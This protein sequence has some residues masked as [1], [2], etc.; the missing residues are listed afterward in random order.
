MV[1]VIDPRDPSVPGELDGLNSHDIPLERMVPVAHDVGAARR[2]RKRGERLAGQQQA[3]RLP[4]YENPQLAMPLFPLDDPQCPVDTDPS[5]PPALLKI[6][7]ALPNGA[8]LPYLGEDGRPLYP[9]PLVVTDDDLRDLCG[10]GR[11][12]VELH[13]EFD[14]RNPESRSRPLAQRY[15]EY[16]DEEPR[17]WVDERETLEGRPQGYG[18]PGAPPP[19]WQG[20]P[21][22]PGWNPSWGQPPPTVVWYAQRHGSWPANW[23]PPPA[24]WIPDGYAPPGTGIAPWQAPPAKPTG[25]VAELRGVL[26][27]DP[28]LKK[29]VMGAL[30]AWL[31]KTLSGSAD[32]ED[33]SIAKMK[34]EADLA[35]ENARIEQD[36]QDRIDEKE[37]QRKHEERLMQLQLEQ[38]RVTAA[39]QATAAA[40][41]K[42]LLQQIQEV[43]QTASALGLGGSDKGSSSVLSELANLADTPMGEKIGESAG[44]VLEGIGAK[45]LS[46]GD[47]PRPTVQQ[48]PAVQVTVG[49]PTY[50]QIEAPHEGT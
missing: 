37:R 25:L 33:K 40:A 44:R 21:V 17:E 29:V 43:K 5:R 38:V 28:D 3:P 27:S 30:G 32:A 13:P 34:A 47:A 45:F 15:V 24:T 23:S 22:V 7:K 20:A 42:G 16:G 1:R 18:P 48:Q 36:R 6:S 31:A 11:F 35:R 8:L 2:D 26:D 9:S 19:P 14:A 49:Q 4:W 10:G 39:A 12:L 41:P 50:P 46:Q